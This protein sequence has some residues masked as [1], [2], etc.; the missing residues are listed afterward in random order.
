MA[1]IKKGLFL[2]L[3]KFPDQKDDV[4]RLFRDSE[5][6]QAICDDYLKSA[7]A[8]R[9][10]TQDESEEAP[11]RREEYVTLKQDLEAEILQSL[12]ESK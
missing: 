8:L 10:W 2:V 4:K 3:E 7:E 5:T 11:A 6:F 1:I 12:N 9:Y